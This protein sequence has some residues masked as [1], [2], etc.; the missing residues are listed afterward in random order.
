MLS[1]TYILIVILL[2]FVAVFIVRNLLSL[3]RE[4]VK[5]TTI[6]SHGRETIGT[7]DYS[8]STDNDSA[9]AHQAAVVRLIGAK[10]ST[11]YIG[12]V[13]LDSKKRGIV[14]VLDSDLEL[15][16]DNPFYRSY[17]YIDEQGYI[18]EKVH[19][20][21]VQVG[22][23]AKPS[24]PNEPCINGE[25]HWYSFWKKELNV[26]KGT[27]DHGKLVGECERN[28]FHIGKD[29]LPS[30][31]R[32]CAYAIFFGKM[33]N[34]KDCTEYYKNPSNYWEDTALL[35]AIVY[36]V[37]YLILFL[38]NTKV[39]D[40]PLFE[41]D[42]SGM[43]ALSAFYF[44]VWTIV[45][46]IKITKG[47]LSN[48]IKP[49]LDLLNKNI[50]IKLTDWMI[51][52][53]AGFQIAICLCF[54]YLEIYASENPAI[55]SAIYLFTDYSH[56]DFDFLPV[57]M[58]IS[59]GL[60]INRT[61]PNVPLPWHINSILG[62]EADADEQ[63]EIQN[64]KGRT[65]VTYEWD[66]DSFFGNSLHGQVTLHFDK[67][68]YIDPLRITNPFYPRMLDS[69]NEKVVRDMYG[70]LMS[71]PKTTQRLRYLASYIN[72]LAT[73]YH[74]PEL[75]KLQF[76]LNF[77]QEPNIIYR[78]DRNSKSLDY[79]IHY[80]RYP[81]ETLFD[82]EGDCDCK[83]F[84]AAMM[85]YEMGY[86]VLFMSSER[87]MSAAVAIEIPV[88]QLRSVM[89]EN[90]IREISCEVNGHNYVYCE[91]VA[92]K[93]KI[94]H[95]DE[96]KSIRD[97]DV[98]VP[99]THGSEEEQQ[100]NDDTN[101]DNSTPKAEDKE[102]TYEWTL[103]SMFGTKADGKV[104]IKFEGSYI[105]RLRQENPFQNYGYDGEH[106]ETKIRS[107]Y[108]Y[109]N[110]DPV[111]KTNVKTIARHIHQIA[112]DNN[113]NQ[114]DTIQFILDFVQEPNITYNLDEES[115]EIGKHKEYI[116]YPDETLYDKRGDCD[117]K[118]MLAVAL[119]EASSYNT[120][121]L[122]STSYRHA[123]L[124]LECNSETMSL[125]Q[126]VATKEIAKIEHNGKIYL[127]CETTSNGFKIGE[128]SDNDSTDKFDT[129]IDFN[130]AE[131]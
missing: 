26:Y 37:I 30:E 31:A 71:K 116:R 62:N 111:R 40:V 48:S 125:L 57:L 128:I 119:F 16:A 118:T 123:A 74:L 21:N 51:T 89:S 108:N 93:F 20:Q 65:D 25:R 59:F 126:G 38:I 105:D 41:R 43:L 63:E 56:Y 55:A 60:V 77:V 23:T 14:S 36:S 27:P 1:N 117:C 49:Q 106:F 32:A 67:E 64:P 47:E 29:T 124:A 80:M 58:A 34:K 22:Y 61:Q 44:V 114:L 107:M 101:F 122:I 130:N 127:Y 15:E 10:R 75:D 83:A 78:E 104:S 115:E 131:K 13:A 42:L 66:L 102:I 8:T 11:P 86:N 94:G 45:R 9:G 70:Y 5:I 76:A 72:D 103:D 3:L 113:L 4:K 120:L 69:I 121:F 53:I 52:L 7:L 33:K 35:A 92:E 6:N 110:E 81:D 39:M 88:S 96:G 19:N 68:E 2:I 18:Y 17:G 90:A 97:F 87:F 129:I 24:R 109:L 12:R 54:F 112:S 85:F 100:N 50:G 99:M 79:A 95:I 84:L 91:V 28:G 82:K 46:E 73:H 98:K